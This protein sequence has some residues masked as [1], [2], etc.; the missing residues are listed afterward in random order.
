MKIYTKDKMQ[1]DRLNEIITLK[2]AINNIKHRSSI[3][4]TTSQILVKKFAD[5]SHITD[6]D[7][8]AVLSDSS[9]LSLLLLEAKNKR[10]RSV[11]EAVKKLE[12]TLNMLGFN[13]S[14]MP[15]IITIPK[16]GAYSRVHLYPA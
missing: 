11:G 8:I 16:H 5:N 6:L 1:Q 2:E 14:N 4:F 9:E 13:H 3:L 15:P 10:K 12:S 7:T